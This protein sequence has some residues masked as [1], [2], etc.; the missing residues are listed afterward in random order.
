MQNE[1]C[2]KRVADTLHTIHTEIESQ[3]DLL[4]TSKKI[5]GRLLVEPVIDALDWDGM[6]EGQV[7]WKVTPREG[8]HSDE[9]CDLYIHGKHH[10]RIVIK[11]L[12]SLDN[13]EACC[14]DYLQDVSQVGVETDGRTWIITCADEYQK[15]RIDEEG[16][17][18]ALCRYLSIYAFDPDVSGPKPRNFN[19]LVSSFKKEKGKYSDEYRVDTNEAM[20]IFSEF[21]IENR[22]A[23]QDKDEFVQLIR[24]YLNILMYVD[25][26]KT[27]LP[28][29]LDS[30]EGLG[31]STKHR[32]IKLSKNGK[33]A[34]AGRLLLPTYDSEYQSKFLDLV[35]AFINNGEFEDLFKKLDMFVNETK[36]KGKRA[37]LTQIFSALQPEYFMPYNKRSVHPLYDA[38]YKH[39]ADGNMGHYWKFND[40]YKR[41]S[42]KTGMGF[43]ELD[44]VANNMYWE[45]HY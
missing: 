12:D 8:R 39:L 4:T 16:A 25:G 26:E 45:S 21:V 19:N 38:G 22:A 28:H 13:F 37:F 35:E 15:I 14:D 31:S 9:I 29:I 42:D 17:N 6:G 34:G 43:V 32:I 40:L 3:Y 11:P 23:F 24:A 30:F 5:V 18:K 44:V 33:F 41:L 10:V 20:R 27:E 1:T 2:A 7:R 36:S